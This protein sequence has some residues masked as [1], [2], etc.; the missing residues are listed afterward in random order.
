MNFAGSRDLTT[1]NTKKSGVSVASL[2]FGRVA[3]FAD[4]SRAADLSP[5]A[6]LRVAFLRVLRVLRGS[7]FIAFER[8]TA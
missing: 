8:V 4:A 5:D 6:F 3:C 7:I 1:K 2:A